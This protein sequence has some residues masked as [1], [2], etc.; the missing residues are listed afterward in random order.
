M[1]STSLDGKSWIF[2]TEEMVS[3]RRG[4]WVGGGAGGGGGGGGAQLETEAA[5]L[6]P[7]QSCQQ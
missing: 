1:F 7:R 3:I 6:L 2:L 4:F 5:R